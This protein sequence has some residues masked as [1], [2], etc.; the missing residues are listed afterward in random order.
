VIGDG[1]VH[2][3][4]G[5]ARVVTLVVAVTPICDEVDDHVF[6]ELLAVV[7]G[8]LGHT[9]TR[10]SIVTVDVEDR[11]LHGLG[12]VAAVRRRTRE[13][14]RGGEADLVVDD[15]VDGSTHAVTTDV[16]HCETLGNHTLSGK[17]SIAVDEKWKHAESERWVDAVLSCAHHS[18]HDGIHRFEMTGVGRQLDVDH[19][20]LE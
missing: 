19:V 10:F 13:L 15:E 4:L 2:E 14:R 12:D 17:R 3:R 8:Q 6:V 7:V 11:S 1:F 5:V 18:Q 9:H 20:A 16:A